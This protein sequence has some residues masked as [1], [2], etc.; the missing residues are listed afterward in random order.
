MFP[1]TVRERGNGKMKNTGERMQKWGELAGGALP[2]P[3]P[4][5]R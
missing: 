5:S 3:A 2:A 1:Q 4:C